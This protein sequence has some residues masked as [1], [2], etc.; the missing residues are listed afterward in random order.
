MSNVCL[1]AIPEGEEWENGTE[2]YWKK[3]WSKLVKG[4]KLSIQNERK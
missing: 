3:F 2:K 1:L 4:L